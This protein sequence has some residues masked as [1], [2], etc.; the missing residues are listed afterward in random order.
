MQE[1]EQEVNTETKEAP[2]SNWWSIPS[3]ALRFVS[4][5]CDTTGL[6]YATQCVRVEADTEGLTLV[7]TDGRM[8][9]VSKHKPWLSGKAPAK[10]ITALVHHTS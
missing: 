8:L 2:K 4:R 6:R 1:Q 3:R 9:L 10:P 7:A 5:L